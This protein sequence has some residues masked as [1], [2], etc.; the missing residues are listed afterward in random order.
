[1]RL[2]R[3]AWMPVAVSI[4]GLFLPATAQAGFAPT[5]RVELNPPVGGQVPEVV[6]TV[7]QSPGE[8]AL[9]RFTLRFPTGFIVNRS[10]TV[11][12]CEQTD[13]LSESCQA[14]SRIGRISATVP[15]LGSLTG[16]L[17]L[18]P[19]GGYSATIA[20]VLAGPGLPLRP[21]RGAFRAGL[22]DSLDVSLDGLPSVPVESL[23][24]VLDGG[25]TGLVRTPRDC[26]VW[27]VTGNFT[28]WP[29]DFAVAETAVPVKQ[30]AGDAV[31]ISGVRASARRFRPARSQADLS[32]RGYGTLLHWR[33]SR[34]AGATRVHIERRTAAG[35]RRLGSIVGTGAQGDNF[36]VFDGKL[37]GR[38]LN[39]G[40]YRFVFVTR[41]TAGAAGLTFAVLD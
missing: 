20:G 25:D 30:C 1:M 4:A 40:S 9:R 26:G 28:S 13:F 10:L 33:L 19:R 24:V 11:P 38:R 23:S 14:T 16:P 31:T 22:G 17:I 6:A 18:T 29:G 15:G 21:I 32:R 35:W 36:L 3:P 2:A 37:H 39:P 8:A 34:T 7:T 5:L 27:N 12:P 41:D